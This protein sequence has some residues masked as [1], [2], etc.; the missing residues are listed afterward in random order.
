LTTAS[1][2][3]WTKS[4]LDN[5]TGDPTVQESVELLENGQKKA[6]RKFLKERQLPE[7]IGNDLVQGIQTALQGL[8]PVPVT[9][10]KLI[11]ALG[12]GSTSC[13]VQDFRS[14][15]E[16]FVSDL[17]KGNDES[18]VRIVIQRDE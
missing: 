13:T 18:K 7:K 12:D 8:T 14:R 5:L 3:C 10:N 11:S 1:T 4:L 6:V 15:F 17:T 2:R 16:R 9:P